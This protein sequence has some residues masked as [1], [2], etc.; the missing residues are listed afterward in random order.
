MPA[1]RLIS[2]D[3]RYSHGGRLVFSAVMLLV[4]L[5]FYWLGFRG[6]FVTLWLLVAL[7]INLPGLVWPTRTLYASAG[8]LVFKSLFRP[9][10]SYPASAFVRV[11]AGHSQHWQ[12]A[13]LVFADDKRYPVVFTHAI[14]KSYFF[15]VFEEEK[16]TAAEL[17]RYIRTALAESAFVPAPNAPTA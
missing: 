7:L 6:G 1:P 10:V 11:E 15:L 16:K 4:I 12:K 9:T 14:K 8:N 13:H 2:Y 17:N 3:Y 5:P